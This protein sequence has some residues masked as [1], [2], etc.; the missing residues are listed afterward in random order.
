M[1]LERVTAQWFRGTSVSKIAY[2]LV[3]WGTRDMQLNSFKSKPS[4]VSEQQA[5]IERVLSWQSRNGSLHLCFTSVEAVLQ[6][7]IRVV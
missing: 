5:I 3:P 6:K 1:N 7:H 4:E 2:N